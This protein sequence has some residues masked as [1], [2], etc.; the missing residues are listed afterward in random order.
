MNQTGQISFQL[1]LNGLVTGL[2]VSPVHAQLL[3]RPDALRLTKEQIAKLELLRGDSA[4]DHYPAQAKRD[5]VDGVVVVDMLL[6][7]EGRVLEAQVVAESPSGFGLGLAALD[8]AKTLEF[9]NT[10][11]RQVLLTWEF[12]FLP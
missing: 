6:N 5:A 7:V 2:A 10:F 4:F 11:K 12:A 3:V 1:L 8:T 9:D